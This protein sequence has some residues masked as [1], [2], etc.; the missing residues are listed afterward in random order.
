[1]KLGEIQT[2]T[3]YPVI[4]PSTGVE[5]T[6]RGFLIKEEKALLVAHESEDV[7]VQLSTLEQIVRNCLTTAPK[8]LT[9]FDVEYLFLK[10]RSK[11]VGET[12][13]MVGICGECKA[14]MDITIDLSKVEL[15]N[16][17]GGTKLDIGPT[18]KMQ[19]RY[20][21]IQDLAAISKESD[22]VKKKFM[23]IGSCI[24]TIYFE[25]NVFHIADV[26]QQ[27][28]IDFLD[29]RSD[30]EF[31]VIDN[32]IN[33]IPTVTLTTEF[34]CPHCQHDNKVVMTTLADFF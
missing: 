2:A 32:F 17:E 24:Q 21:S 15:T 4:I 22:E 18:L 30:A 23:T 12:A 33:N 19:M 25:D 27:E 5:T 6:Y 20:P 16:M 34:K 3:L 26:E 8:T 9:T 10:M 28:I 7:A 29:N 1:M 13:E 14:R 31:E 11:S